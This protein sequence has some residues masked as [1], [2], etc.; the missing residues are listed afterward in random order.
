MALTEQQVRCRLGLLELGLDRLAEAA[1]LLGSVAEE[2]AAM[3]LVDADCCPVPDLVESLVRLGR[4]DEARARL[5]A[6]IGG[7][8]PLDA[9][10]A[11]ARIARCEGLLA[12]EGEL[13]SRFAEAL[14]LESGADPL[15][16]ARTHLCFG[17]RLRRA[18]RRV[19]ARGQ[20]RL[21]LATF[22]RLEASPWAER[23]RRELRASGEK[24]R[25]SGPERGAELTPQELQIALQVAEGKPNKEVAGALFLSP[26]TVEFHLSRIYR[27]LD[28]SSRSELVHRFAHE[29]ASTRTRAPGQATGRRS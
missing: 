6:W 5:S 2:T 21:A 13:E 28:M 3:G 18:G 11:R 16:L 1:E 15:A 8:G 9:P 20:L 26:K 29:V 4:A 19:D 17:E 12:E 10:W 25:R 27:K 14:R 7:P 24:L 23:A 22:E